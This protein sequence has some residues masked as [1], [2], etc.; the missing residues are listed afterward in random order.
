M[1]MRI[2]TSIERAFHFR[3]DGLW[4]EYFIH[5]IHSQTTSTAPVNVAV[6]KK[7]LGKVFREVSPDENLHSFNGEAEWLDQNSGRKIRLLAL[8]NNQQR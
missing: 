6:D 5:K 8:T 1:N 3:P 2:W 4:Q 7:I